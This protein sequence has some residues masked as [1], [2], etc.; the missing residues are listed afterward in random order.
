MKFVN[1]LGKSPNQKSSESTVENTKK[2][3]HESKLDFEN[4]VESKPSS[5]KV[6]N[7]FPIENWNDF[8]LEKLSL[9]EEKSFTVN[10]KKIIVEKDTEYLAS[11][12]VVGFQGEPLT[13]Y[14]GVVTLDEKEKEIVRRIVYFND[15]SGKKQNVK[16]P[17]RAEGNQIFLIYRVNNETASKSICEYELLPI[18]QAK[19]TK[20]LDNVNNFF[21]GDENS[22]ENFSRR[23]K[24]PISDYE[25][26]SLLNQNMSDV[27]CRVSFRDIMYTTDPIQYFKAG[28][29]VLRLIENTLRLSNKKSQDIKKILDFPCGHGRVLRYLK[30][31]FPDAQLTAGDI[32][33]DGVDFCSKIFDSIPLYSKENFNQIQ[34][35]EKFDLI[36]CGS[37]FTH[38]NQ[39]E[40]DLLI[41]FFSSHLS[42]KGILV[43]TVLGRQAWNLITKSNLSFGLNELKAKSL[44]E[45]F[46]KSGFGFEVY[47]DDSNYGV[48][49]SSPSFVL[50]KFE[51]RSDMRKLIYAEFAWL[52]S[53]DV[54]VFEKI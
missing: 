32:D 25:I 28:K 49:L 37:L 52:K 47:S 5:E 11:T 38:I 30:A 4:R 10:S 48:S 14:F 17:F 51:K 29:E 42:K 15:F 53:Q 21:I 24:L 9:T 27:N 1:R 33:E 54:I 31:Y 22:W 35:D 7:D 18:D 39:N 6:K 40:W 26:P 50:S 34:L 45:N 43:F 3:E 46:E 20:N 36:F 2:L 16:L 12:V 8:K 23:K 44:A 13:G 19:I 41:D